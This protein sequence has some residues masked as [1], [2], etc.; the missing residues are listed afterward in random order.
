MC[1]ARRRLQ[2]LPAPLAAI[3]TGCQ[4][5]LPTNSVGVFLQPNRQATVL[6]TG[7]PV[8]AEVRNH[9]P[10][11]IAVRVQNGVGE[12]IE[13]H[14]IAPLQAAAIHPLDVAAMT[15]ENTSREEAMVRV[16]ARGQSSVRAAWPDH[17]RE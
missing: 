14:A 8:S 17:P 2:C 15:I 5:G 1:A 9:G 12:W 7:Q 4:A 13:S 10:G 11:A 6:L 3:L 16:Y